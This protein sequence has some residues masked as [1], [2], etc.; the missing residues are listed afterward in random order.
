MRALVLLLTFASSLYTAEDPWADLREHNPSGVEF[1]LRLL[2]PH[3][4]RQGEAIRA[5]FAHSRPPDAAEPPSREDWQF[6]GLL[7]DPMAGCG[8]MAKPCP[9]TP[10]RSQSN[11]TMRG[12]M[13][14]A[15]EPVTIALNNYLP[16]L[17]PGRYRAAF[18]Y[19][20]LVVREHYRS[21]TTW[22]YADPPVY[23]VSNTVEFE[24][25]AADAKWIEESVAS[26]VATLGGPEAHTEEAYLSRRAAAEQ[27][28]FLDH[29][30]AWRASLDLLPVESNALLAGLTSSSE[31]DRV[32]RLMRD[33]LA[34]PA[35]A[36]SR[37]YMDRLADV[38][39]RAGLP[40][41]PDVSAPEEE[42]AKYFESY[43]NF[44]A[45]LYGDASAELA[46]SLAGKGLEAKAWA[47]GTLIF[48]VKDL[49]LNE[50]EAPEPEW[51][52]GLRQEFVKSFP[53]FGESR[54]RGLLNSVTG[55]FAWPELVPVLE[56][57]L[58]AWKPGD[59]YEYPDAALRALHAVAPERAREKILE[60]LVKPETWLN[61]GQL[62]MLPASAVSGMDD[63]LIEALAQAQRPG[64]WNPQLRM[65]A[66]A[67]Y[68]TRDA[69]P[70]MKAIYES[71]ER[72]C[73]PEL[74]AYFVRVD[75]EYAGKLFRGDEWDMH[76]DPAP[77]ALRYFERTAAL[78]MDPVLEEYIAAY[79]MHYIVRV[80]QVAARSLAEHGSASAAGPLWDAFRYFHDYWRDRGEPSWEGVQLEV[81]LR[82]A[83]AYGKN[84]LADE[85]DLRL[86]ESLCI[87]G[88]CVQ[89]TREDLD[90]W[91]G[92]LRI[93]L[94]RFAEGIG[95]SVA[96]YQRIVGMR[97]LKSKLAQFPRGTRFVLDA[98]GPE[99][100]A[101]ATELRDF[102]ANHGLA[103]A[104]PAI[105]R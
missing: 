77:C 43:R 52:S 86:I 30:I 38:C 6:A 45:A 71:Q 50:P 34:A 92:P 74:M 33:R 95:G 41:P 44:N 85:A 81:D 29:P 7:I 63:A 55:S 51:I 73:Q 16:S 8:D 9:M 64:G 13:R 79:L 104:M 39:R 72:P 62:E 3:L 84:W 26:C 20:K 25:T 31:P 49:R 12:V 42:R 37:Y 1:S 101:A 90:Y 83:I 68:A 46:A 100:K 48:R 22:V 69:L 65:A 89:R 60:E 10:Q 18:L 88:Q 19:R 58:D 102:A 47:L 93:R 53:K 97:D 98:R 96:Q 5:D 59:H 91:K 2:D 94:L 75:P 27:L 54:R 82:N 35:Q 56:S 21:S 24:V 99:A 17:A 70:R 76:A 15:G 67:R 32:C 57:A 36:V 4:Y 66:L 28:S 105:A 40:D 11:R 14:G 61:P 80:K 103:L 78:A 87:T 23:A